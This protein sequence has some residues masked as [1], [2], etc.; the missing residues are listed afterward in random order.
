[1]FQFMTATRIIFGEGAL[2]NS[3]SLINNYGYS[4]LVVT[5]KDDKRVELCLAT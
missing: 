5:G 3:L 2:N 4:V 1:M